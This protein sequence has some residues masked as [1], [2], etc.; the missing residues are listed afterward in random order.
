VAI[1]YDRLNK[2]RKVNLSLYK[3]YLGD[4]EKDFIFQ[5][6]KPLFIRTCL[7]SFT[8]LGVKM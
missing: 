7:F 4:T 1:V 5:Q 8:V 2:N 3:R 6:Y